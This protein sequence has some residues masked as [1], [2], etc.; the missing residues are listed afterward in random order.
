MR[1]DCDRSDA[2]VWR[3]CIEP[4]DAD[5]AVIDRDGVIVL[6]GLLDDA[7]ASQ[8]CRV[9]V[10]EGQEGSFCQGMDLSYLVAHPDEDVSKEA[11]EYA[12]CLDRLRRLRQVVIAAVDGSANGGGVGLAAAA[13]VVV[14]TSRSTFGLPE[15]VLGLVP[16]IVLPVLLERMTSQQVRLL[17]LS[18]SV[19]ASE[20]SA[21]GLVDHVVAEPE[22]L[23]RKVRAIIK[24]ALRCN[25]DAVA[26][27]KELL[28][29]VVGLTRTEGL[30]RGAGYTAELIADSNRLAPIE[31]FLKGE[32]LPWFARYRP[33]KA[34]VKDE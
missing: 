1:L 4:G 22:R 12:R 11:H 5:Q 25:P 27:V 3:V 26:G 28:G 10:M 21:M 7:E 29:E 33:A 19:E 14:A 13:D 6:A 16:A 2:A 15:V 9:L 32:P 31:G 18:G 24:H 34:K 23:E 30:E 8:E 20:A 17:A